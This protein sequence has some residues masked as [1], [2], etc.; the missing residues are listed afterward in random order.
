MI[1]IILILDHYCKTYQRS[2]NAVE[3]LQDFTLN[4]LV[5]NDVVIDWKCSCVMFKDD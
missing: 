5:Y 4:A 1:T 2:E 3:D